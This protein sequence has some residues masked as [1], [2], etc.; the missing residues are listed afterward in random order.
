[1]YSLYFSEFWRENVI[2][3]HNSSRRNN[4]YGHASLYSPSFRKFGF[5]SNSIIAGVFRY[6]DHFA[7]FLFASHNRHAIF[8]SLSGI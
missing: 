5:W 8:V 3:S 6:F 4:L 7:M 2:S 1:M